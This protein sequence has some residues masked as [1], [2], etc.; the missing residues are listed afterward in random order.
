MEEDNLHDRSVIVERDHNAK[1]GQVE[2]R[3]YL[4]AHYINT[5]KYHIVGQEKIH[6]G[7][8]VD[9]S[10]GGLGMITDHPLEVGT[11]LVFDEEVGIRI[12]NISVNAFITRW[13]R[14]AQKNR[15]R[16]GLEFVR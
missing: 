4:R 9:I 7:L 11:I 10:K 8:I 2:G 6:T 5:T 12:N 3:K 1:N 14:E 16:V 15:Y 13:A